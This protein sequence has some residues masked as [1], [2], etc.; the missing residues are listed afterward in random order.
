[1]ERL[2]AEGITLDVCPTS[3]VQLKVY[4]DY[5]RHPL[6]KLLQAGVKLSLNADD[7]LFF[8]SG[9]LD[10]YELGRHTFGLTDATLASIAAT[11]IR[12]SGAPESLKAAALKGVER[13]LQPST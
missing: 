9:L 10:E 8:G 5:A 3:N 7:P 11:S 2:A 1:M 4:P 12:A 13:W 6:P